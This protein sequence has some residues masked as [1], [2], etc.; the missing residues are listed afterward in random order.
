[1]GKVIRGTL[2]LNDL[3]DYVKPYLKSKG[4]KKKNRRWT[5]DI[6]DFTLC[7]Y[8]QGSSYSKDLYY[9]RPG[10]FINALPTNLTYGHWMIEIDQTTPEEVIEKFEKWCVEWTDKSLIRKRLEAFIEWEKRN[11][12]EKRRANLVDYDADPVPA[13]EF[14]QINALSSESQ[15]FQYIIDN[16]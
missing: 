1:M 14:F 6:G 11:P 7:F 4:F 15:V 9:I 13:D 10:I 16:F 8:I 5:K 12:L 3:I 2:P